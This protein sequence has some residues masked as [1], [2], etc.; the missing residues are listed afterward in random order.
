[1]DNDVGSSRSSLQIHQEYPINSLTGHCSWQFYNTTGSRFYRAHGMDS[2][3]HGDATVKYLGC[4]DGLLASGE[5]IMGQLKLA[6]PTYHLPSVVSTYNSY[7]KRLQSEWSVGPHLLQADDSRSMRGKARCKAGLPLP[8]RR[9]L[10][11]MMVVGTNR[12]CIQQQ[13]T[14]SPVIRDWPLEEGQLN[15]S[16]L[17]LPRGEVAP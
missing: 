16:A 8:W 6:C 1:M 4:L 3:V 17:C 13:G 2:G 7:A 5:M 10:D 14:V 9:S 12:K 15:C 11:A